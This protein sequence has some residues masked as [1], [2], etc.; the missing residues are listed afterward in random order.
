MSAASSKKKKPQPTKPASATDKPA[1]PHYFEADSGHEAF[2]VKLKRF[3][4]GQDDADTARRMKRR[5]RGIM[6][7][8]IALGIAAMGV[9]AMMAD[10]DSFI[11]LFIG[12]FFVAAFAVND[13]MESYAKHDE[14]ARARQVEAF[15]DRLRPDLHPRT[16][17]S[18]RLHLGE[19][20]DT[21][22][23]RSAN[24]P[25]SG[26]PKRWYRHKWLSLRWAFVD[27]NFLYL[28]LTDLVKTKSGAEI[29]REFQVKGY[30]LV[31]PEVYQPVSDLD[32]STLPVVVKKTDKGDQLW[33]GGYLSTH[34]DLLPALQSMY[35]SLTPRRGEMRSA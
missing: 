10:H 26:A 22:H 13:L 15:F 18:S 20:T 11:F 35:K 33:F 5:Q 3:L 30:M 17:V 8:A 23:E 7:L 6:V 24:S 25:Y 32:V 19:A 29:R 28:E 34:D 27:G 1:A 16:T 14:L 31:N 12:A 2:A 4:Q 9:M 21:P